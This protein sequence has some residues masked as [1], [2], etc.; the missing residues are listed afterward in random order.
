MTLT[1]VSCLLFSF[2]KQLWL[3]VREC[4]FLASFFVLLLSLGLCESCKCFE[5]PRCWHRLTD[6]LTSF[7]FSY[8]PL[9]PS[10]CAPAAR[11]FV[12]L[13][14]AHSTVLSM[15]RHMDWR[16]SLLSSIPVCTVPGAHVAI[17][18]VSILFDSSVAS[19]FPLLT[20]F[21]HAPLF[22]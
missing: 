4:T 12:I 5:S 20:L 10:H 21:F 17:L 3:K 14:S 8:T 22:L 15:P 6:N 9:A 13:C 18:C 2:A 11:L 1:H 7:A 19:L 16:G